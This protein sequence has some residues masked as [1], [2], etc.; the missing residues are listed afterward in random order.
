MSELDLLYVEMDC[1]RCT[2]SYGVAPCTASGDEKC[3]NTPATCQ[4]LPNFGEGE[5]QTVRWVRSASYNPIDVYAVPSLNTVS[6]S[7]QRINPGENLGKRERATCTFFNHR[8][9]DSDLDP[10]VTERD[11]NPFEQGTYWGKFAAMYPNVQG[12]PVRILRGNTSLD[13]EDFEASHYIADVG[14]IAGDNTGYSLTAKDVLDFAEG[15]KTLCPPPSSGLLDAP[16]SSASS[17]V[18]LQPTGIGATYPASFNASIG[19][20]AVSCTISGDVVTFTQ[21]GAFNTVADAHDEGDTLQIMESFVS[22]NASQILERLLEYTDTPAEYYNVTK[23][24]EQVI[25]VASPNLTAYIAE[26]TEVF[27]LIQDLMIDLALDIHTD[28]INKKIIMEFLINKLPDF[29]IT[30]ENMDNP[31]SNFFED[32]RVDL[33]F[34]SFGRRN[35]LEKMDQPKNY[36]T[37]IVR[38]SSNAVSILSGNPAAIRRHYSRWIPSTLR[39]QASKTAQF[40]VGRYELAPRG[41]TCTMQASRSPSMAQVVTV[42]SS[43]FEDAYGRTPDITMQVVGISRGQG[44]NQIELEEFRAALIEPEDTSIIISLTED[45]LDMGGSS[46]LRAIYDS[47]YSSLPAGS[48]VRFEADDGV[49]FGSTTNDFSLKVGEWPEIISDGVTLQIINLFIAGKGGQGGIAGGSNGGNALYTRYDIELIDC[50]I[51]GGGGGGGGGGP[52]YR[53]GGGG[54]GYIAGNNGA[55]LTEGGIGFGNG[56]ALGEAG[57][58]TSFGAGGLAGTAIDGV[59]YC[60]LTSTTVYGS[61]IN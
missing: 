18:T 7:S 39:A 11:Y 1:P 36:P 58:T 50:T 30:D 41:L 19:D 57:E 59:S 42:T 48:N 16:I 40:I 33:F 2:L 46:S 6:V 27:K 43:V 61:Q 13:Y 8:H 56:G 24:N 4:D 49:V 9:N 21:R 52:L 15:N 10:Y 47:V 55:T 20:E 38:P 3:K 35:P 53:F 12:Y 29:E 51:G 26:P 22:Q 37:T 45:L 32:K 54:A 31:K 17:S 5:T 28:V 25:T 60:T 14:K 44:N 23:W 34:M